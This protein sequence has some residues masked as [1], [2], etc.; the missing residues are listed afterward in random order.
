MRINEKRSKAAAQAE[1]GLPMVWH[2]RRD[3]RQSGKGDRQAWLAC[4][5]QKLCC[6]APA[7]ADVDAAAVQRPHGDLETL[8]FLQGLASS[9][10]FRG[11]P[12]G[13]QGRTQM[14]RCRHT[15]GR[16][17]R[18]RA[19]AWHAA[20]SG[21][22]HCSCIPEACRPPKQLACPTRLS[23]GTRTL[24][25]IYGRAQPEVGGSKADLLE[26]M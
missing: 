22:A 9:H 20:I 19:A 14:V 25:I 23:A 6:A 12:L 10:Q 1:L 2:R 11:R 26:A 17:G 3:R 8:P 15:R 13:R 24:S 7:C 16:A 4:R 5:A 18:L 21:A